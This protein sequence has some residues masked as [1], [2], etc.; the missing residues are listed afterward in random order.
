VVDWQNSSGFCEAK[1]GDRSCLVAVYTGHGHGRQTQNLAYSNDRGRTW[2][3]YAKNPVIDLGLKDF[4]DPKTFWHEPTR[5]WIMVTVLPDQHKVRLFASPDLKSWTALSDF[6]PAG[7]TGGVWECPDLFPLPIEGEPGRTRW[8]LDVDINPGGI[9][10]GSAGQYFVGTF[11]GTRFVPDD[12]PERTLWAD[13]GKDFY[14]SISFSDLP[15]RDG[16]RIWMGWI[17]NWLYANQEPT[18]TWRGAQSV[19]RA[20]TLRRTP[21][22]LR[23]VQAPIAELEALRT[24]PLPWE[25][26]SGKSLPPS[27]EIVL[28]VKPGN[29]TE[30]GVRLS[31]AAGEEV[32]VGVAAAPLEVFVDRRKSRLTPFHAAYAGRH[33]GPV[34]WRDGTI[35]LRILFDR[36]VVEVFANGGE[37]VVT[38][39]VFPTQPLD[40]VEVLPR[41]GTRPPARMW[42]LGTVR[43]AENSQAS[44]AA[45][46]P[47]VVDYVDIPHTL[48]Q[49][50]AKAHAVVRARIGDA[51][52]RTDARPA[53]VVHTAYTLENIEVLKRSPES[54][55][56]SEVLRHGGELVSASGTTRFVEDG[57]PP[58]EAKQEYL[59]FLYWN[60]VLKTY[61]MAF[62]PSAA[63]RIASDG[64][65]QALGR[66]PVAQALNQRDVREVATEIKRLARSQQ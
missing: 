57:F 45:A 26:T 2:T 41:D 50:T 21:D 47:L 48:E 16:R 38:D 42:T 62:G 30:A 46:V 65:L 61:E 8:V 7:A 24:T 40:R 44:P 29:W 63:F 55:P 27:A 1:G 17:S 9:A 32:I 11:D 25:I 36:S 59:L 28:E 54:P 58:F 34:A 20:L 15:A 31:N 19:P 13:Y 49:G 64:R 18:D 14:A 22:G 43:A 3:K 52:V 66:E 6:G 4:R 51:E 5:R 39:R 37:T 10:G 23:L 33:A 56:P 12:P 53:P 35:T 60:D